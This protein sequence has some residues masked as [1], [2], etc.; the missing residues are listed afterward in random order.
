MRFEYFCG[1]VPTGESFRGTL[2]EIDIVSAQQN[3]TKSDGINRLQEL[4]FI[5]LLSYFESFCKDRFASTINIHPNLI[6]NL[7]VAG[8]DVNVDASH[9]AVPTEKSI[10]HAQ[11]GLNGVDHRCALGPAAQWTHHSKR[12]ASP[13]GVDLTEHARQSVSWRR[14]TGTTGR[15]GT[16][17]TPRGRSGDAAR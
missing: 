5:G 13:V 7:K 12:G 17:A 10:W 4:C 9:V 6:E 16:V 14:R 1:C 3:P 11:H 15:C 2:E 8:Q